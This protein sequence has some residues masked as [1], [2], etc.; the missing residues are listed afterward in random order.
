[1]L[2]GESVPVLKNAIKKNSAIS[3]SSVLLAGT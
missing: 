2:T 1:M 3:S